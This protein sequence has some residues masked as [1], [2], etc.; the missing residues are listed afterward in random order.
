MQFVHKVFYPSSLGY[1]V[2]LHV[3]VGY[4]AVHVGS[5]FSLAISQNLDFGLTTVQGVNT[6]LLV[7]FQV[8]FQKYTAPTIS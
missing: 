3:L 8:L 2:S 7:L 1:P 6:M 4:C 5:R